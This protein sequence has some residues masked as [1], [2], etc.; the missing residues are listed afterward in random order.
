MINEEDRPIRSASV[1]ISGS[2]KITDTKNDKKVRDLAARVVWR[3]LK[4][5][6]EGTPRQRLE[7]AAWVV[8]NDVNSIACAAGI[9][10]SQLREIAKYLALATKPEGRR[11]LRRLSQRDMRWT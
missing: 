1:D 5:L 2:T 4:D 3:A 9:S 10:V 11:I 8:G 7:A 6:V